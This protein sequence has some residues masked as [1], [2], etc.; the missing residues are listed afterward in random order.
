MQG[1][2]FRSTFC[3]ILLVLAACMPPPSPAP[4]PS[5]TP[6]ALTFTSIPLTSTPTAFPAESIS[7]ID[8]LL[9]DLSQQGLFS[10]SVLIGHQGTVLLGKGYGLADHSQSIRNTSR[11]RF[12]IGSLTK[13][14]TA[15]AVLILEAQG[16]LNV[17][18]PICNYLTNCPDSWKPITIHQLL[19]HTSGIPN[20]TDLPGILNT[21]ATP[22]PPDQTMARFRDLPLDFQPGE[23]WNYSNSGY[24]IL[25][26]IIEQLSGQSYEEFLKDN[27]FN[28]L[29]LQNTGYDHKSNG[30]AVGYPDR[31]SN[32]PADYIDMSIPYSA[33]A[34]YSTVEDLYT[35]EQSLLTSQLVPQKYVDEM[36]APQVD[37]PGS[38]EMSYGYGWAMGS[39][40]GRPYMGHTGQMEGFNVILTRYPEDQV[41]VI[42]L[43]NQQNSNV[44]LI[45]E[46]ISKRIFGDP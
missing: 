1:K 15:M 28:P 21:A 9:A 6:T 5:S 34:L 20:F 30:L 38:E 37:I 25:G 23:G 36:L 33:G 14:F 24:V 22:S 35:W 42:V 16:K 13:Q 41:T 32:L 39:E 17:T 29:H 19:T 3:L 8:G 11:T 7:E 10:G 18:D 26:Y 43:S 40:N 12:R 31:Y 46:L 2:K 27:I 4:V 45:S 44:G